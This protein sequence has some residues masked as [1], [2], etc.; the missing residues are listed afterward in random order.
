MDVIE[1]HFRV[2]ALGMLLEALHQFRPLHAVRV[3]RPI[4]NFG[5]GHQLPALRQAG[6]ECRLEVGTR[7]IHCGSVTGGTRTENNEGV[8]HSG[9]FHVDEGAFAG[10]RWPEI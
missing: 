2:E 8:M 10:W 9:F 4:V 5:G 1:D 7:G 3:A 6:D